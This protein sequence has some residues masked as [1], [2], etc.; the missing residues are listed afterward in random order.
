MNNAELTYRDKVAESVSADA[1]STDIAAFPI[2]IQANHV[3]GLE[4]L[5][6]TPLRSLVGLLLFVGG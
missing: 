5:D 2:L 3:S 4:Y 6:I 1:P